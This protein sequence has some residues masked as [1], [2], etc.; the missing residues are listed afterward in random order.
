MSGSYEDS[1]G[2]EEITDSFWEVGN[3]KRS[4]KR[5]D[6]GHRLCNDLMSCINERAK[7]E[8]AYS[9]QLTDWSKRWKQLIEKGPQYGTLQRAW[10]TMMTEADRVSE[11]HQDVRNGLVTDDFEKVKNWQKDMYHKQ[12]IGGFKETKEAE[13]GFRKAQ[14]PWAKKLKEMEVAKKAYHLACKEEKMAITRET[15]SK[16]DQ[17]VTAD[18]QKKLQDKVDKCKQEV[19]KA[20]EKYEKGLDELG[21]CTP[22]YMENMEQVFEQCQQFEEKRLIFFREVLQDIKRHLNLTENNS[23]AII[24]QDLEQAIRMADAQEDLKWFS[25]TQGPGMP[26]NWPQFEEYSPDMTHTITKREKVKKPNE[27]VTLTNIS[28]GGEH[29][30]PTADR[31]SRNVSQNNGKR[32]API[33]KSSAPNG[34]GSRSNPFADEMTEDMKEV[35]REEPKTVSSY[36][37]NQAYSAEWSD[38]ETNNPAT[39]A[40]G[41]NNPFDEEASPAHG[42]GVRVRALYDYEGQEQ[43]ELSFRAGDFLIKMEDEDEQGWC[44]GQLESGQLGLYPANYVESV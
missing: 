39:N 14:K 31:G 13:D 1:T 40:N 22:Q 12:M 25:N 41:G 10:M 17:S 6:D 18:Q 19:Q 9:Q 44:K 26:M 2:S 20:K 43:D 15:N 21:K 32:T 4:V 37:K 42:P 5:I 29:M 38:D 24:Y 35:Q 3:Y 11:L 16:A 34:K 27:G 36:D 8:K 33:G 7:I 28:P 30:T 23:Y